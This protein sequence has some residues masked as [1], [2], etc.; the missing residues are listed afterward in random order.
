MKQTKTA[1]GLTFEELCEIVAPIAVKR[2][3]LRVYLFGS[4]ARGDNRDDSDYDFCILA[5]KEYGLI[6]IGS[7]RCDLI[8]TLGTEVDVVCEEGAQNRPHFMEEM[9]RDRRVVF[10]T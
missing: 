2:G 3:M 6:K 8:D 10:E 1:N 4:R 5:P 7:F 9:L